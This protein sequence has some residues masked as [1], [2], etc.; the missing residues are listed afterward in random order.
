MTDP[1]PSPL[2]TQTPDPEL[3]EWRAEWQTFGD[4]KGL[5]DLADRCARDGRKMR[6]SLAYETVGAAFSTVVLTALVVRT[7]GTPPVAAIAVALSIFN[8]VWLA[9]YYGERRGLLAVE[10]RSVDRYV[11]LTRRRLAAEHALARFAWNAHLVL[12]G[13]VIPGIV[14]LIAAHAEQYRRAP[15]RGAVGLGVALSI[16]AVLFAWLRRKRRRAEG[17]REAFEALVARTSM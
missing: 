13:V 3:A 5:A 15:W 12:V 8:G 14:W 1:H 17:D 6:R 9:R 11:D 10:G 7:R 16:H 4:P 2:G